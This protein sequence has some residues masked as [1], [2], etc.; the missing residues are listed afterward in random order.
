M[1]SLGPK[2]PKGFT[3]LNRNFKGD[4]AFRT[5]KCFS[6]TLQLSARCARPLCL[7]VP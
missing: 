4:L 5:A 7:T 3:R 6:E 1:V 2:G